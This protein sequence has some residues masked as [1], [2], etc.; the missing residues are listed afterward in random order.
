[1]FNSSKTDLASGMEGQ[2]MP[3]GR[4]GPEIKELGQD[5]VDT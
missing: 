3:W 4:M 2:E 1:M 5:K